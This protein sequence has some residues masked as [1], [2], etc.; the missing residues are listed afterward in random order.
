[1]NILTL[2]TVLKVN[3]EPSNFLKYMGSY[4]TSN[5]FKSTLYQHSF[6]I[7]EGKL[8]TTPKKLK[9]LNLREKLT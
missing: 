2:I 3:P 9:L 7:N 4:E 8:E 6:I 5:R 1:L